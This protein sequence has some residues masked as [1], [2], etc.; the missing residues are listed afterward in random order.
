[1][2]PFR[3]SEKIS[4]LSWLVEQHWEQAELGIAITLMICT[5][6]FGGVRRKVQFY[7]QGYEVIHYGNRHQ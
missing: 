3:I 5:F 4:G 6:L 2:T 1:M 7:D